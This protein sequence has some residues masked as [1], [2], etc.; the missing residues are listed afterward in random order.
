MRSDYGNAEIDNHDDGKA[1]M[2]AAYWGTSHDHLSRH[3]AGSGP[4]VMAD[5]ADGLWAG[6]ESS[7]PRNVP[8]KAD[9]VTALVKGR[10]GAFA[11]K[12]GDAQS[13]KLTTFYEGPTP[14]GYSPMKKQGAIILG[15]GGDNSD[16][17][18]GTFFEGA[19][20]RGYSSEATDAAVQA[21]IVAA[22]YGT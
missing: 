6:N 12:G 20:T 19:I 9:F 16:R 22:G 7:N 8:I 15:I 10:P 13:G 2:E 18:S 11:V 1:T 21:S 14:A 3:G 17:A 4:W 5:L